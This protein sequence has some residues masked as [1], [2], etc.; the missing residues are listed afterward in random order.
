MKLRLAYTENLSIFV[1][2]FLDLLVKAAHLMCNLLTYLRAD[3]ATSFSHLGLFK[4]AEFIK[5]CNMRTRF[6]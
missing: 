1:V 5:E 4:G 2:Y 6:A 3:D